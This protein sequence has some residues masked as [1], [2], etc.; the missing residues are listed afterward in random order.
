MVSRFII[1][2]FFL[3]LSNANSIVKNLPGFHGDL[4]FTL[5]T[6]YVGLGAD[7]ETQF[8]YYFVESQSD[9]LNDPFLFSLTGGPGTTG[10]Y[11]FLYQI[12]PL[13]INFDNST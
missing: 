2:I 4:P 5:E 3:S 11:P 10:L 9:P 13:S 6:G 8:F 12:G 1:F 7:N